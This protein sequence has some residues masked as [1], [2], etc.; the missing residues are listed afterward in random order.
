MKERRGKEEERKQ[1]GPALLGGEAKGA[2]RFSN[3]GK[4]PHPQDTSWDRR[5][6]SEAVGGELNRR[7]IKQAGQSE[8]YTDGLHHNPACPSLGHMFQHPA[9]MPTEGHVNHSILKIVPSNA[10]L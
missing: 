7:R 3:P 4:P 5:R 6:A 1:E 8:T 2:E 9:S 10:R